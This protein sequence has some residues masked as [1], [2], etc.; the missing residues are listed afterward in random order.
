MLAENLTDERYAV[1]DDGHLMVY[2][3][4]KLE[5]EAA[6]TGGHVS[7]LSGNHEALVLS[8]DLRYTKDKYKL[9][10]EKLGGV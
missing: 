7:F 9:L 3:F 6:K 10:A 1:S 2:L 4:Y 8:N 5:D